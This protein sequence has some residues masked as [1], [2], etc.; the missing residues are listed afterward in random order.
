MDRYQG[1]EVFNAEELDEQAA[2]AAAEH[3]QLLL[4][5]R[6]WEQDCAAVAEY[7][8]WFLAKTIMEADAETLAAH[9]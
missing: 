8:S 6:Q 7:E 9:E 1:Q 4:E 3:H 2:M 5:R